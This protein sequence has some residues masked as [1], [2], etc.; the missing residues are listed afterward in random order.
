V[1]ISV[2]IPTRNRPR[3]L[4]LCLRGLA[5]QQE[6][7]EFEVLVIDDAG[8]PEAHAV[9]REF[10]AQLAIHVLRRRL[11]RG[12]AAAR[13]LAFDEISCGWMGLLDDDAT[14]KSDWVKVA[15]SRLAA[16]PS[17]AAMVGR[18]LAV[19]EVRLLS[20]A[21][22]RIYDQRHACYQ[23]AACQARLLEKF[24]GRHPAGCLAADYLSGGNMWI[25]R[26]AVGD[27][28]RFPE[29]TLWGHDRAFADRLLAAGRLLAY[30]PEL[31]I[32]HHHDPRFIPCLRK[33]FLHAYYSELGRTDEAQPLSFRDALRPAWCQ[34]L[35][36]PADGIPRANTEQALPGRAALAALT[37]AYHAGRYLARRKR[38]LQRPASALRQQRGA[39]R[40]S[41]Q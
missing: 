34:L 19:D 15:C 33:G 21:R 32:R 16:W 4:A 2:V 26:E 11:R 13:N 17:V 18:I 35:G 14:P 38:R 36:Q 8:Y 12:A 3:E 24:Q 41:S 31:V 1:R 39:V 40:G 37:A 30:V 6:A 10:Q 27:D 23:S 25:R 7:G 9:A 22:Q 28:I 29:A 20:I 5:E